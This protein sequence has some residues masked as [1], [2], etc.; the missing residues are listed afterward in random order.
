MAQRNSQ[1][2]NQKIFELNENKA[3]YIIKGYEMKLDVY[4]R[5]EQS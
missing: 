1:K 2:E 4:I 5:K 3:Q